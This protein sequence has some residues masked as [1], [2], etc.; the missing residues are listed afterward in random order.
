VEGKCDNC[1]RFQNR[2][3]GHRRY[4]AS[5]IQV[6]KKVPS[7]YEDEIDVDPREKPII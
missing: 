1:T 7:P 5:T 4:L 2:E 6:G 3:I